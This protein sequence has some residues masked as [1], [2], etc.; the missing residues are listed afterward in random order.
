M[1]QD[2]LIAVA[3][4]YKEGEDLAPKLVAKGQRMLAEK[5][6]KI[7]KENGIPIKED[8]NLSQI[9]YKLELDENIPEELYKA[10]AEILTF[11]YFIEKQGS[12]A[13]I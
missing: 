1:K 4:K 6:I 5:I 8:S 7:A 10:V 12:E 13:P 3:L 2:R 9:L 11:L